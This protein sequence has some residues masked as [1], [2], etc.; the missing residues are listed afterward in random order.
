MTVIAQD[1]YLAAGAWA[2]CGCTEYILLGTLIEKLKTVCD[3][4]E[5]IISSFAYLFAVHGMTICVLFACA[6]SWIQWA[7]NSW[8]HSY[9]TIIFTLILKLDAYIWTF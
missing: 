8:K 6:T 3:N 7:S 9:N 2:V 5:W 4:F 1:D